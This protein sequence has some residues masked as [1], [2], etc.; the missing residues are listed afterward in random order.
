MQYTCI[1]APRAAVVPPFQPVLREPLRR[2]VE[3]LSR[4]FCPQADRWVAWLRRP[5]VALALAMVVALTCGIF[6]HPLAF[7]GCLAILI[8]LAIGHAWPS[9][10]IRGLS[11]ELRFFESR[12]R[13]GERVHAAV[14]ITNAWPWPVWGISIEVDLGGPASV[15]LA[16]VAGR[17]TAEFEWT[18]TVCRRGEYPSASPLVTTGFPF[19]LRLAS[20][21]V[22]TERTLLV[23]PRTVP[24][25][26]L[27]DAAETRPS[28]DRF[29]EA[30]V[31]ES[32]DNGGTRPFR[33][34]DSLRRV[35][36]AQTAR[37]GGMVVCERQSP[38]LSAVR[39][40]FDP[41]PWLHEEIDGESTLEPTI[42]IVASICEAYH[43]EQA[44][45][46]CCHGHH[47]IRLDPGPAGLRRFLD[48]LARLQPP[49]SDH[50]C[51]RIHHRDC[52]TFQITVTTSL[53]ERQRIEHRHV[54]GDE[55]RIVLDTVGEP[56]AD[57]RPARRTIRVPL[58]PDCLQ[59]FR[60]EWK[61]VCRA[62]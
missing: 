43:R 47:T 39:V 58:S 37:G 51:R 52:G 27:L 14:A 11:A 20:R 41:E 15:A 9:I 38:T 28:D 22:A 53:G 6:M 49:A 16:S 23:W 10:A 4:D 50:D 31:G 29:S 40:V 42:R 44:F 34:G 33:P 1:S 36:W 48:A 60:H 12:V 61:G 56:P 62:G 24:L 26:T 59:D 35:H 13:E 57:G 19:G 7:V 55:L 54:H 45:V 5:S 8:V 30:R 17:S 46:E 2:I 25:E 32:G 21:T 3:M 18:P